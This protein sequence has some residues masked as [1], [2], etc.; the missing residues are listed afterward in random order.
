MK[1]LPVLLLSFVALLL[2]S[3]NIHAQ[4]SIPSFDAP[5]I[6]DPT[7]FEEVTMQNSTSYSFVKENPF[8]T[9]PNGRDE[10]NIF[11]SSKDNNQ[12]TNAFFTFEIYSL[13]HTINYGPFTTYEGNIFTMSL[14][15]NIQWGIRSVACSEGCIV[16]IWF[17]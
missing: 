12:N 8:V 14:N 9:K 11:V 4:Y 2:L 10:K 7:T 15:A 17:E 1:N 16:D 6:A 5:I 13:D 3:G